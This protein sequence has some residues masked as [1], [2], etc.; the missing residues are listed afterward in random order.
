MGHTTINH[1]VAA[2]AAD[3]G[4][5]G[6]EGVSRCSIEGGGRGGSGNVGANSF[7]NNGGKQWRGQTTINPKAAEMVVK[8][9]VL[10]AAMAEAKTVA[11]GQQRC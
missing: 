6:G 4:R 11:E 7:G 8:A 2:I 1:K 10:A 5:C 3:G 9:A